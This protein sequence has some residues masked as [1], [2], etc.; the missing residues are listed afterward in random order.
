MMAM[1]TQ[2]IVQ[3]ARVKRIHHGKSRSS[4][5]PEGSW[6]EYGST[7]TV[8]AYHPQLE[9][10]EPWAVVTWDFG[11]KTAIDAIDEGRLW[12]RVTA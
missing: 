8:T 7:G 10:L 9:E 1:S 12:E 11:G 2:F 6:L 5:W 3:G 4:D